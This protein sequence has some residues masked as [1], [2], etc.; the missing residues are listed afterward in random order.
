MIR[1]VI[2]LEAEADALSAFRFYEERREGLGERFRDHLGLALTRA[3]KNPEE[4]PVV[5]RDL[6]RK[7]VQRFPYMVLYRIYP[8]VL[9]V[10]A[11][12][13]AKQNPAIWK[14]RANLGEP[15]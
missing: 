15:G 13:H 11:V 6:R 3:Q 8:G 2:G 1:V 10:V 4:A 7:L 12:M 14:R 5:Y 9:Y